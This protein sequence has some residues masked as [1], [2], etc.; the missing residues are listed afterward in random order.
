MK[1][2]KWLRLLAYVDR[3]GQSGII[4]PERVPGGGKPDPAGTPAGAAGNFDGCQRLAFLLP[5]HA[6]P[7]R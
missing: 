4:A 3:P 1:D 7:K 5:A 2:N 6:L